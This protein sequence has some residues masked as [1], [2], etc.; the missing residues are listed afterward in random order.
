MGIEESV[1][2]SLT[3]LHQMHGWTT[4]LKSTAFKS[5]PYNIL[6]ET[7]HNI[8]RVKAVTTIGD[9]IRTATPAASVTK[10]FRADSGVAFH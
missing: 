4:I 8:T 7:A 5:Q 10:A 2:S 9:C 6:E 3:V 1:V